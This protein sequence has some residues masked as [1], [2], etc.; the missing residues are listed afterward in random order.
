MNDNSADDRPSCHQGWREMTGV[1]A[2]GCGAI[3]PELKNRESLGKSERLLAGDAVKASSRYGIS[4]LEQ[5]DSSS[6]S[7]PR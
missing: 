3:V 2:E 7:H 5:Q 6:P 1:M 4:V